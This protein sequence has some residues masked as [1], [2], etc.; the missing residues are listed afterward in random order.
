LSTSS[1]YWR[2]R[3]SRP[4]SEVLE[5]SVLM[6]PVSLYWIQS[7]LHRF[8][9]AF[10]IMSGAFRTCQRMIELA[11]PGYGPGRRASTR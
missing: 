7:M 11:E 4:N 3:I 1:E 6:L 9:Y 10:L 5:A 8:L 2:L